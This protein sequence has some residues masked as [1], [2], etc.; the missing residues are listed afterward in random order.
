[1]ARL[2][3]LVV[4]VGLAGRLGP[5]AARHPPPLH[6]SLRADETAVAASVLPAVV[7]GPDPGAPTALRKAD[8]GAAEPAVAHA[9]GGVLAHTTQIRQGADLAIAVDMEL[10]PVANAR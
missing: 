1:M 8:P 4:L 3:F 2:N 9:A 10:L 7:P 5:S 6:T